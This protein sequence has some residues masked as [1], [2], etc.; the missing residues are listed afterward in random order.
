[1][2]GDCAPRFL[3]SGGVARGSNLHYGSSQWAKTEVATIMDSPDS[4]YGIHND[5]HP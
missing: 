5:R 4:D 2:A 1:M 3:G